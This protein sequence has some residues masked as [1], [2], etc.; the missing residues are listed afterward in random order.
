VHLLNRRLADVREELCDNYV[1][2]SQGDGASFA[3]VL[4]M[5]AERVAKPSPLPATVS[6]FEHRRARERSRTLEQ[7]VCRLLSPETTPMTRMNRVGLGL[8]ILLGLGM[9]AVISLSHVRAAGEDAATAES[10]P[11]DSTAG[12][13]VAN[14]PAQPKQTIDENTPNGE[15]AEVIAEIEGL[16][17]GVTRDE[18]R[19]GKPVIEV[20]L[21]GNQFTDA[22]LERLQVFGDLQML[23]L[24]ETR[25]TDAGVPYLKALSKLQTVI[26]SW[27][28]VSNAF[29]DRL[30][31]LPQLRSVRLN[32]T[33]V[34]NDGLQR[35]ARLSQL[36]SLAL[37]RNPVSNSGMLHLGQML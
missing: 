8:V 3:E 35:L 31:E 17:G 15:P 9:T 6:M 5:L 10:G 2:G 23:V 21:Y 34:R 27:S 26:V 37:S 19:S 7:R 29:L 18:T 14:T 16:G 25:I 20:V 4:V 30:R 11:A 22:F 28:P 12:G 1:L 32:A 13:P 33:L 36:K 24:F